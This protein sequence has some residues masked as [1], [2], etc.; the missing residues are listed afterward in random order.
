MSSTLEKYSRVITRIFSL[1]IHPY[2]G[3]AMHARIVNES[4]MVLG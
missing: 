4:S 1:P 2:I 3:K